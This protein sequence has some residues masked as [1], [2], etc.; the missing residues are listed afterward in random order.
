MRGK[1]QLP[2]P[3]ARSSTDHHAP[4]CN[5]PA[6]R[7]VLAALRA[8]LRDDPPA[9]LSAEK[10]RRGCERDSLVFVGI[11]NIAQIL[12][13]PMFARLKC[14]ANEGEMFGAYL[15]DRVRW[16][17]AAGLVHH[18][19]ASR[20]DWLTTGDSLT[21][22]V[23]EQLKAAAAT[24]L[25]GRPTAAKEDRYQAWVRSLS[26]DDTRLIASMG[27]DVEAGVLYESRFAEKHPTLR[28]NFEVGR[29]RVIVGVPDG[30]RSQL[31]YEFKTAKKHFFLE[32]TRS[33]A[34]AQA[35]L[36]GRLF[37]RTTKRVQIA[38]RDDGTLRTWE[39]P[40]DG[41][42]ADRMLARFDAV[43]AGAR[44]EPPHPGKCLGCEFRRECSVAPKFA[45]TSGNRQ[46][47]RTD[48]IERRLRVA[49]ARRNKDS[50]DRA[51][52]DQRLD[53]LVKATADAVADGDEPSGADQ[54]AM[55]LWRRGSG[56]N[57]D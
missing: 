14:E 13:C 53:A 11:H 41:E 23:V 57:E 51:L 54:I 26:L 55:P 34:F 9:W 6:R 47:L 43:V 20:E 17:V 4:A 12:W 5:R 39:E 21:L 7:E 27:D 10:A 42:S 8:A 44:V 25:L 37:G 48:L 31:V 24:A 56:P 22:D 32:E 19:P 33:I 16:A 3:G 46:V 38:L 50:R 18:I 36:Y 2:R 29:Q 49:E 40:V 1:R 30:L 28:W 15:T 45:T 35:D 52:A